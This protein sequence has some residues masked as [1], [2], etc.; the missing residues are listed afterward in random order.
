MKRLFT[1]TTL[2]ALA[3]AADAHTQLTHCLCVGRLWWTDWWFPVIKLP[4]TNDITLTLHTFQSIFDL[5]SRKLAT[6]YWAL[7]TFL[8]TESLP[9]TITERRHANH[10]VKIHFV[11]YYLVWIN[12]EMKK[13]CLIIT[14]FIAGRLPS[15]VELIA[16]AILRQYVEAGLFIRR[17]LFA[18]MASWRGE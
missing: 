2:P 17:R 8:I 11:F 15:N 16:K 6:L 9:L 13:F 5:P 3:T 18:L 7:L 1:W 4:I 10:V 12:Q 14:S